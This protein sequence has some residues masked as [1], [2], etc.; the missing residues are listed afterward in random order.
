M[1]A[2]INKENALGYVWG[3]AC[4]SWVLADSK[5]LSIKQE[6]MPAHTKEQWHFHELATQFF[7]IL[8][9][10]ATFY[11]EGEVLV[12][13]PNDGIPVGNT[14]K[15]YIANEGIEDLEFLVISEPNTQQDRI[16]IEG[17]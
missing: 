5:E 4:F 7:Y 13:N 11:L 6:V 10:Q 12:L 8:K 17:N 14:K 15:H 16:N 2:K 3:E 1:N 9:G